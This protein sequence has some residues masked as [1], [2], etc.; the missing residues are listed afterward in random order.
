VGA[1]AFARRHCR[2]F[3]E[4]AAVAPLAVRL[5]D[6]GVP[7]VLA[8]APDAVMLADASA[9]AV[10]ADVPLAVMVTNA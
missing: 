7:A 1:H 6:A 8:L 3:A 5:A 2:D 9:P 10:L 4:V